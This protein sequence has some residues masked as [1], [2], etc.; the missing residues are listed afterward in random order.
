MNSGR[1]MSNSNEDYVISLQNRT[2]KFKTVGKH[3]LV[4]HPESTLQ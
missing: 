2:V 3:L 4:C 1:P